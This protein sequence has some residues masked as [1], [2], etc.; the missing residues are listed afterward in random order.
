MLDDEYPDLTVSFL[1]VLAILS[2]EKENHERLKSPSFL[3]K[4]TGATD[5]KAPKDKNGGIFG[6]ILTEFENLD[7][8][9]E[10]AEHRSPSPKASGSLPAFG[11]E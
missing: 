7:M 10:K 8:K 3:S 11:G 2:F 1:Q 5:G 4:L 9:R 6:K